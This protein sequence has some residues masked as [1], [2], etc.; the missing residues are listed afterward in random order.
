[1]DWPSLC[2]LVTSSPRPRPAWD[3]EGPGLRGSNGRSWGV[4]LGVKPFPDC[5]EPSPS[6]R[7]SSG[8]RD[9]NLLPK[10]I[11]LNAHTTFILGCKFSPASEETTVLLGT[12]KAHHQPPAQPGRQTTGWAPLPWGPTVPLISYPAYGGGEGTGGFPLRT[13]LGGLPRMGG[14]SGTCMETPERPWGCP[15]A[16]R[17]T[18]PGGRD[19]LRKGRCAGPAARHTPRLRTSGPALQASPTHTGSLRPGQSSPGLEGPPEPP[20][21]VRHL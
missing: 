6:P 2:M 16:Q 13:G 19:R 1:M 12:W 15:R 8:H 14:G 7:A 9:T 3:R 4:G 20:C 21:P 18:C 5:S 17:A 10:K 11:L